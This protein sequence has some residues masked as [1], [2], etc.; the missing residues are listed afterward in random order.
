M[1]LVIDSP[2]FIQKFNAYPKRD[3]LTHDLLVFIL[4]VGSDSIGRTNPRSLI[5]KNGKTT[6]FLFF[7][8][9]LNIV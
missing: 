2:G 4:D 9:T 6:L 7:W 5:L 8:N 1:I 3:A